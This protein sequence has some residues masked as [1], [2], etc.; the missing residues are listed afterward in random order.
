[1]L[2]V[3]GLS[4]QLVAAEVSRTEL[5]ETLDLFA[6]LD[7]VSGG[8][9]ERQANEYL[10]AKLTEYG[11]PFKS[12]E[13]ELYLSH[14][15]SAEV[16]VLGPDGRT[17]EAINHAFSRSTPPDGIEGEVIYIGRNMTEDPFDAPLVDYEALDVRGHTVH[18]RRNRRARWHRSSSIPITSCTT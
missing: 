11:V 1:M 8:E 2:A 17:I 13:M 5:E 14:P 10:K 4:H 6:N 15:L 12:Y 9:G 7:R 3:C 18:G 16:E